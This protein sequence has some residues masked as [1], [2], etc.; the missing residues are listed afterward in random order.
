LLQPGQVGNAVGRVGRPVKNQQVA[1]GAHRARGAPE[2]DA[3]D[4]KADHPQDEE[5][6]AA[7]NDN[8]RQQA[9][10]GDEPQQAADEDNGQASDGDEIGE[11][12][13]RG[14]SF[15]ASFSSRPGA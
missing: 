10:L 3:D 13:I 11:V 8:G 7:H 12:P 2:L 4:D 15:R 9:P 1:I 14:V 6:E 5:D